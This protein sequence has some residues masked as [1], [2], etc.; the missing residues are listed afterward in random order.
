MQ[1]SVSQ[2]VLK[3]RKEQAGGEGRCCRGG[4]VQ[5]VSEEKTDVMNT[6][7]TARVCGVSKNVSDL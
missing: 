1:S 3:G 7:V 5:G 4:C 6:D 2:S